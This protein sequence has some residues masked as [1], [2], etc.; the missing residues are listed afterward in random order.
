MNGVARHQIHLLRAG[1][2]GLVILALAAARARAGTVITSVSGFSIGSN[3]QITY[4]YNF[5]VG[6]TS[7]QATALG[8]FNNGDVS[9]GD[10]HLAGLW[11]SGGTLL[12]AVSV[13]SGAPA[14]YAGDFA[15]ANLSSPV[16]LTAGNTYTVGAF[17]PTT[18]DTTPVSATVTFDSNITL[19]SYDY[20]R[21]SSLS[22]PNTVNGNAIPAVN[23]QF[24][25][26]PEPP[27]W[28]FFGISWVAAL[29]CPKKRTP[30]SQDG[31]LRRD[32]KRRTTSNA[33]GAISLFLMI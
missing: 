5:T 11:D 30:M 27:I 16:T 12:G 13:A 2:I 25:A 3:S 21:G 31:F 20:Q 1:I 7:L 14:D 24:S 26:V 9:F 32:N 18:A 33:F 17:F 29:C 28:A 22:I 15:Y 19:N 8:V 10:S 4:G 6:A 23:V